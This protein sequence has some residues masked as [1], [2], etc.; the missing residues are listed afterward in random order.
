MS[1]EQEKPTCARCG[2]LRSALVGL[3]GVDGR[4]ELEAMEAFMRLTPAPAADKAAAVD[5]I[6]VLLA[7]LPAPLDAG[8]TR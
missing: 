8:G 5:A 6:H 7:T 3:I 4:E 2:Q 1:T